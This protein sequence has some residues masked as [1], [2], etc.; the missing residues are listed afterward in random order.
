MRTFSQL[1][2]Q[3]TTTSAASYPTSFTTLSMNN[4]PEN[5]AR[6]K[7]LVNDEHRRL[8]EKYFDNERTYSTSILGAQNITF[9]ASLAIG[10]TS[11]TLNSAWTGIT[12]QQFV[13]FSSGDQRMCQF[14]NGS[15]SITW[16]A[17]LQS[18]ATTAASTQGVRDYPIPPNISKIKDVTVTVGQL[19]FTPKP[20]QTRQEWD[21]INTIPYTSDI[22]NYYFVWNNTVGIWPI[23]STSNNVLTFNYKSR[24]PDLTFS[25]YTT[26][27]V[28]TMTAGS[29]SVVGTATSW[30]TT[31]GY[32]TG[33]DISFLN[34]CLR[35]DPPYGDG[36]WYQI[37][38]FTDDT[39]LT[40]LQPVLNAP[41]ITSSSTYTI[42]QLP[43]LQE[44]FHDM[45]VYGALKIY[46]SSIVKDSSRF[47][48]YDALYKDRL[49][50]LEDYAGTKQVTVDL[51]DEQVLR[52]PNLYIYQSS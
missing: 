28:T 21:Y 27:N 23:P 12:C 5:V 9:T 24:F 33:V 42:A 16:Q 52:N 17:G 48:M 29:Y 11:A 51:E 18:T 26:G 39:H 44:D 14:T 1:V 8:L 31:G 43:I 40:L 7:V 6:G 38:S 10:A 25:D 46:Y 47:E 50:L 3:N 20:V 30:S 49:V 35:V 15:T 4:S 41:N 19:V 37:Q 2:G 22:P 45:M 34:L 32:P 36:I 13:N